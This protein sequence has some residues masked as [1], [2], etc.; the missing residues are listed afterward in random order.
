MMLGDHLKCEEQEEEHEEEHDSP[1]AIPPLQ[2]G[3]STE[4]QSQDLP[5][6]PPKTK[7]AP[8]ASWVSHEN[9]DAVSLEVRSASGSC[10]DGSESPEPFMPGPGVEE[11]LRVNGVDPDNIGK[12]AKSK[13]ETQDQEP[14]QDS[15][16]QQGD[17]Q[18]T[19]LTKHYSPEP[20]KQEEQEEEPEAEEHEQEEEGGMHDDSEI[21]LVL[22]AAQRALRKPAGFTKKPNQE[23]DAEPKSKPKASAKGKAK[24]KCT[25]AKATAKAKGKAKAKAKATNTDEGKESAEAK[26]TAKAK[27][28]AK[29]K[30]TKS[31]EV[32]DDKPDEKQPAKKKGG[33]PK[34]KAKAKA[35]AKQ[36]PVP[37]ANKRKD[38]PARDEDEEDEAKEEETRGNK[39]P[40]K[41][42]CLVSPEQKK[43]LK[44][45]LGN[46][47]YIELV[48]VCM[49]E[50]ACELLG[51]LEDCKSLYCYAGLSAMDPTTVS[52]CIGHASSL[53]S[54]YDAKRQGSPCSATRTNRLRC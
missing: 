12:A 16:E 35:K 23:S 43:H 15:Q 44:S 46:L 33:W 49:Y 29:A 50:C 37:D 27:G 31:Q 20:L 28:K 1:A 54:E 11:F 4:W 30:G 47:Y 3:K 2:R 19:Q 25:A 22:H 36:A 38:P 6:T 9:D 42:V 17:D 18:N 5:L 14:P 45:S 51:C 40:K 52:K 26:P 8:P 32:Q 48:H 34:G 21:P 13:H 24:A 7:L 41:G 39:R 10:S 53:K